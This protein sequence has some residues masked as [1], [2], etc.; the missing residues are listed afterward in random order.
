MK[1]R[2]TLARAAL[3]LAVAMPLL[4]AD[5]TALRADA[6][7]LSTLVQLSR[8]RS[9]QLEPGF[10]ATPAASP[11][12]SSG[13]AS[14]QSVGSSNGVLSPQ[15]VG[16]QPAA[17]SAPTPAPDQAAAGATTQTTSASS[18]SRGGELQTETAP[19]GKLARA[20]SLL[21]TFRGAAPTATTDAAHLQVRS[22]AVERIGRSRRSVRVQVAPGALAQALATYAN[23]SDVERVEPDYIVT[24]SGT[25]NDPK[26]PETWGLP[27]IGAPTAWD[28]AGT[29]ASIKV[30]ILDTGILTSHPDLAGKVVGAIDYTSSAVGSEDRHGHGTHVAGTVAGIAN[31]SLGI[32]GVAPGAALLNGKVLN[33]SGAGAIS[34]VANGIIWATD[35]GAKVIS[36][37]LGA[38]T[39]CPQVLQEAAAYAWQRGVVLV[40]AAGNDGQNTTHTP[41]NCTNVIAAAASDSNDTRPGFSNYGQQVQLAGPGVFVLSTYK[42]GDYMWMSGTSMSTPHIA[43]AA[44]LV[45]GSSY[46]TGNQAVVSRLYSTADQIAG[47]GQS[48]QYGRVNVARAVEGSTA[49]P[50]PSPSPSPSPSPGPSP[51]PAPAPPPPVACD[52]RPQ[53]SLRTARSMPGT[54]RVTVVAG[55]ASQGTNRIV[56]LRFGTG[57]NAVIDTGSHPSSGGDFTYRLPAAST[58]VTF[59]VRRAANGGSVTVPLTV[60]DSCGEWQTLI[61]G[62]SGAF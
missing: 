17:T 12:H 5:A 61:G 32:A 41:A 24:A 15:S 10:W 4:A 54:L 56:Q 35:N 60:V 50:P 23:R 18:G 13:P 14:S 48:W 37:S 52:P 31:N 29:G 3:A 30:A 39:A 44:A 62:G 19:D 40:A 21:V 26:Y 8:S 20:G 7:S 46:G 1:I 51:T 53:V 9:G 27:K 22:Q 25:P 36:M 28:R 42:D 58:E 59:T 45:W 47:T 34:N 33:D 55:A 57:S 38:N 6:A 43:G 2:Q 49:G 16:G 11:P